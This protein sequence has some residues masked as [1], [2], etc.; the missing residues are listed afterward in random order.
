M[1]AVKRQA[2]IFFNS[3]RIPFKR[4]RRQFATGNEADVVIAG[5]HETKICSFS[6]TFLG[7]GIVGTC[8]AY[9]IKKRMPETSFKIIVLE[10][11]LSYRAASTVLSVGGIRQQ[12]SVG[13][14]FSFHLLLSQYQH[15][16]QEM[17]K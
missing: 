10:R 2:H 17:L 6:K 1:F 14:N 12:F 13:R 7:G 3:R 8:I 11:D 5:V 16:S 15:R 4:G 9:F